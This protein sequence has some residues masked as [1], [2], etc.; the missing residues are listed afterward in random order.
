MEH[1]TQEGDPLLR[2]DHHSHH[3]RAAA[4]GVGDGETRIRVNWSARRRVPDTPVACPSAGNTP[5]S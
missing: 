3:Q 2:I 4:M 5:R 1:R